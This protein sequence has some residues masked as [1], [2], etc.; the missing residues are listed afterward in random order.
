MTLDARR[1]ECGDSRRAAR[2][3]AALRDPVHR[4]SDR[5]RS[6]DA[7]ARGALRAGSR[8]RRR[9]RCLAGALRRR[10]RLGCRP[11]CA[12]SAE[13]ARR[14]ALRRRRRRRSPRPTPA[15][16]RRAPPPR[17]RRR[18]RRRAAG[19]AGGRR[20]RRCRSIRCA[21][22]SA[23]TSTTRA[24]R[25]DLWERVRRGFAMPDLDSDLVRDR[26]QLVRDAARLR[27]SA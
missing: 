15:D 1:L 16:R 27:R 20:A 24:A 5:A 14:A 7:P 9:T 17:P 6:P 11:A 13:S 8:C 19:D 18:P 25:V 12:R 23:S 2:G 26:E 3:S 10:L 4:S 21:P 22:R